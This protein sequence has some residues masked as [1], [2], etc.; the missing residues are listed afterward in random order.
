MYIYIHIH[1]CMYIYI[2]VDM[3]AHVYTVMHISYIH[4][5]ISTIYIIGIHCNQIYPQFWGAH[6]SLKKMGAS[7]GWY[8]RALLST[9]CHK[10]RTKAAA[11]APPIENFSASPV[12][13]QTK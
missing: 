2:Y 8:C 6:Q 3:Y 5:H 4:I 10:L 11:V 13:R 12:S 9:D 7:S 1:V